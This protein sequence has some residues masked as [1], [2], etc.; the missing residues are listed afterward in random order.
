MSDIKAV[1]LDKDGVFVNFQ[2]LWFRI[3]AYRAQLIAEYATDTSDRFAKVRE[4]C[5]KAM[6]IDID[7]EIIDPHGPISTPK[8]MVRMALLT[9]LYLTVVDYD[10]SF[11]WKQAVDIVDKSFVEAAEKLDYAEMVEEVEGSVAKIQELADEGFKLAIYT[12]DSKEHTDICLE[13]L[14]IDNCFAHIHAGDYKTTDIYTDICKSLKVKPS[15]TIMVSDCPH[16]LVIA[17]E[18][19]AQTAAV[20]SGVVVK[21]EPEAFKGLADMSLDSLRDMKLSTSKKKEPVA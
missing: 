12:S 3:I 6:G 10:P 20:F 9:A 21:E 19:G 13:K 18:A 17:K 14:S 11:T 8:G 1:I 15:E 5:I 2:K 16:D 4:A 7:D